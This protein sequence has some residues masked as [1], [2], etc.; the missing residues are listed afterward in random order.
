MTWDEKIAA[1]QKLVDVLIKAEVHAMALVC[2]GALM[3]LHG[4]KDEG[5]LV[6]GAG[7]AVFKGNR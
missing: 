3:C 4:N 5:Q 7:L 1:A 2:C 6:I